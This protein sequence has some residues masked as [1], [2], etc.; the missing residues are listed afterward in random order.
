MSLDY[1]AK[2]SKDI[3][4]LE[5]FEAEHRTKGN[6]SL[7]VFN[8]AGGQLSA[9]VSSGH[10]SKTTAISSW[11]TS[12][13]YGNSSLPQSPSSKARKWLTRRCSRLSAHHSQRRDQRFLDETQ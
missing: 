11:E 5:Q 10:I 3:T 9:A 6:F 13:I 1:I 8:E 7:V 4:K 2:A 12:R